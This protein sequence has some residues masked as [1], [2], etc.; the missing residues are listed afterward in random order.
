MRKMN[1]GMKRIMGVA[2]MKILDFRTIAVGSKMM[3]SRCAGRALK[4]TK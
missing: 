3:R 1:E 2:Y 4:Q